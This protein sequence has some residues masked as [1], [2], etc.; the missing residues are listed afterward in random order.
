[1]TAS[2]T[3]IWSNWTK[4]RKK[5]I[6]I[7]HFSKHKHIGCYCYMHSKERPVLKTVYQIPE[8]CWAYDYKQLSALNNKQPIRPVST[9][10][11]LSKVKLG[12]EY[13]QVYLKTTFVLLIAL[14]TRYSSFYVDVLSF[15]SKNVFNIFTGMI[16]NV[17][18]ERLNSVFACTWKIFLFTGKL[19]KTTS[20]M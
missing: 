17:N 5:T 7:V 18:L 20:I 1:M 3:K 4:L 19:L 15:V 8:P 10:I 6:R 2:P 16:K 12:I 13:H 11:Y 14:S 9:E